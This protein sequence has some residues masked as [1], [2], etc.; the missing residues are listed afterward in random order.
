MLLS[1]V[2]QT[3]ARVAATGSRTAK[4]AALAE[5][6]AQAEGDELE[7]AAHYLS[8][9]LRQRRTGVGW[10]SL[11]G[12]PRPGRRARASPWSRWTPRSRS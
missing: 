4:V 8:G 12:A 11:V 1:E 2:V 3:S 7:I 10:R 6:L 9:S 5:T